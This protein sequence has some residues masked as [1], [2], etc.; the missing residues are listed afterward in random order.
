MSKRDKKALET[1]LSEA[2]D[3]RDWNE[4]NRLEAE[5]GKIQEAELEAELGDTDQAPAPPDGSTGDFE[6][7]A[8]HMS[9]KIG[10]PVVYLV[11][12]GLQ[13]PGVICAVNED[14]SCNLRLFPDGNG[15]PRAVGI[16][17]GNDVGEWDYPL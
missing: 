9:P 8:N 10:R 6:P 5:L 2:G 1:R 15:V 7:F 12:D 14:G 11:Q 13:I 4:V 17:R 16:H 3:R